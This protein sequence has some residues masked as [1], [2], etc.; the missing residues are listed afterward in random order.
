MFTLLSVH[1]ALRITATSSW[2]GLAKCSSDCAMGWFSR[3]QPMM[4]LNL[5]FL[6]MRFLDSLRSLEMTSDYNSSMSTSM[7]LSFFSSQC[8]PSQ[9]KTR[10]GYF[11]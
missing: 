1:C 2:K 7:A 5:S 9:V 10:P 8:S 4:E 6:V 11:S 3:N